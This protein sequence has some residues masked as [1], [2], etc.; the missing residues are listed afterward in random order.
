MSS[1][2]GTAR[3]V[4]EVFRRECKGGFFGWAGPDCHGL[5]WKGVK[6]WGRATWRRTGPQL[7]APALLCSSE[8]QRPGAGHAPGC[9][10][11]GQGASMP[12]LPGA[13]SR[14]G[15]P[16]AVA[17]G[18]CVYLGGGGCRLHAGHLHAGRSAPSRPRGRCRCRQAGRACR[19]RNAGW[20]GGCGR[21]RAGPAGERGGRRS[22]AGKT[23]RRRAAAACPS[24]PRGV[25]KSCCCCPAGAPAA[26][27][28]A[29]RC[30]A[31]LPR[32]APPLQALRAAGPSPSTEAADNGGSC[33][34]RAVE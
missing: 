21:G 17:C 34:D 30:E 29:A 18:C 3:W 8:C 28:W 22:L 25:T 5:S 9:R 26:P 14:V 31:V 24:A 11:A 10:D 23:G 12:S 20:V 1:T 6:G 13:A 32:P 16:D 15:G 33:W 19:G 27:L 4:G 7:A 2:P